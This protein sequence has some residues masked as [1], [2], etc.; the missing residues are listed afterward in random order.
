LSTTS[1][2]PRTATL[3]FGGRTR[4]QA[5]RRA[6]QHWYRN[7]GELGLDL[8]AYFDRCRLKADGHTIVFYPKGSTPPGVTP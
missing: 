6:L 1:P 3:E 8:R 5:K 2:Q 4:G 7:R